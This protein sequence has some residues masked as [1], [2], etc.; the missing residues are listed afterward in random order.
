MPGMSDARV[1]SARWSVVV[2]LAAAMVAPWIGAGVYRA[3][4]VR[5]GV[6]A[7]FPLDDSWIHAQYARTFIEGRPLE[8]VPGEKSVG[9]TSQLFDLV[10]ALFSGVTGE[11]VHTIHVVN[12]LCNSGAAAVLVLLLM[13]F[14]IPAFT[15]GVGSALVF[16]SFPFSWSSLSGMETALTTLLTVSAVYAH[17][18]LRHCRGW[19]GYAAGIVLE[20]AA[21][22]RPENL[23][24]FPLAEVERLWTRWRTAPAERRRLALPRFVART[25]VWGV[26]LLPWVATNYA[27]VGEPFPSTYAAKV[28]PLG[29]AESASEELSTPISARLHQGWLF[30]VDSVRAI[31]AEANPVLLALAPL[32]LLACLSTAFRKERVDGYGFPL[33]VFA[34]SIA[35]TGFVTLSLMFLIQCQRY[36]LHWIPL[37]LLYGVIGMHVLA[38]GGARLTASWPRVGYAAGIVLVLIANVVYWVTPFDA[39]RYRRQADHYVTSVKNINEMQ[40]AL[41]RWFKANTPEDAVI[42]T[43]DIGAIRFFGERQIV[44]T[45]GLIDAEVVRIR[46]SP[47]R[48]KHMLA[49]LKERGVTHAALFPKWHPDLLL[50]PE[51]AFIKR[52]VLEDNVVCGDDRMIVAQLDWELDSMD[53]PTPDWLFE[54]IAKCQFWQDNLHV[55]MSGK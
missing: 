19:R 36:L 15:A 52:V 16:L 38:L 41:G 53:R 2:G 32:G 50:E 39:S 46:R 27:V 28:G 10:W 24:L 54:E 8:Y 29:F 51:F 3:E 23:V 49:Y 26:C 12:L 55:W 44:D 9:S 47:G 18:S 35:A 30:V 40:V 43:N 48:T 4:R 11:Y 5:A 37:L 34:G 1:T 20:L 33:L 42:A 25:A 22:S 17:V 14:G 21:M 31:W 45:V 13:H 7:G 6:D